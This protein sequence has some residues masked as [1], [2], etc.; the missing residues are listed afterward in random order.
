LTDRSKAYDTVGFRAIVDPLATESK[1]SYNMNAVKELVAVVTYPEK[2]M[3]FEA[4]PNQQ[5]TFKVKGSDVGGAYSIREGILPPFSGPPLHIHEN[6]DEVF[7]VLE[8][9]LRFICEREEFDAQN[10]GN[11]PKRRAAYLEEHR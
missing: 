11:H 4:E 3:W 1:R 2:R 6:A 5:I 8:G 9:T 10:H 7:E